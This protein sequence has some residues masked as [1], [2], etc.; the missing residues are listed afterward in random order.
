MELHQKRT[1]SQGVLSVEIISWS[2]PRRLGRAS[3]VVHQAS[4]C[5]T[6]AEN[7]AKNEDMAS[8]P[9]GHS[10][11]L[12]D[13]GTD[14]IQIQPL[15]PEM[16][17]PITDEN[18]RVGSAGSEGLLDVSLDKLK[19]PVLEPQCASSSFTH[20]PDS[21]TQTKTEPE[22]QTDLSISSAPW[23]G[24]LR[25]ALTGA[26]IFDNPGEENDA[27][28]Y[29]ANMISRQPLSE[30]SV[31]QYG[32]RYIPSGNDIDAYRTV[33]VEELPAEISL[34][35]ILACVR[36]EIYSARLAD[37]MAITG[38]NTGIITF[39][40]QDDAVQFLTQVVDNSITLP[41][42][43]VV[44]VCTPT[45]PIPAD[46]A[47]LI[48]EEGH[49][50]SIG[51]YSFRGALN[52]EV[53]SLIHRPAYMF[54]AQIEGI[55]DGPAPGEI[56]IKML[57][58]KAAAAVFALLRG[59]PSLRRCQLRFLKCNEGTQVDSAGFIEEE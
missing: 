36:T 59:H 29:R 5:S 20:H 14:D 7:A 54:R 42:G 41:A 31:F 58:V 4:K 34:S 43:K 13:D 38:A 8:T 23:D 47:R 49:T 35:Q 10:T 16:K 28:R 51:V 2:R 46:I 22:A 21:P 9:A 45:Y 26:S 6:P 52:D 33:R 56:T 53:L 32:L 15:C 1:P 55:E 37:T 57:S 18:A 25:W 17:R 40:T 50:R 19:I 44:P 27:F 48:A 12:L 39:V 30:L 11:D 3:I 24:S